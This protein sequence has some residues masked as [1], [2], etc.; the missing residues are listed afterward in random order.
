MLQFLH[1]GFSRQ[2]ASYYVR[3]KQFIPIARGIYW[4]HEHPQDPDPRVTPRILDP[5]ALAILAYRY[6]EMQLLG[7]SAYRVH[8]G[9]SPVNEKGEIFVVTSRVHHRRERELAT[10]ITLVLMPASP[11][12]EP[13]Q[14][15]V[16]EL[17]PA[18]TS[19]V[20][21]PGMAQII[22]DAISY[23]DAAP[24]S[25]NLI[26]IID[27]LTPAQ[28]NALA[29]REPL[30]AS[31]LAGWK[32]QSTAASQPARIAAFVTFP[33]TLQDQ[34][35]GAVT[36]DGMTWRFQEQNSLLPKGLIPA[37][38]VRA[39]LESLLPE[40]TYLPDED[41]EAARAFYSEPR[42]VMSF[43]T[44]EVTPIFHT[45]PRGADLALHQKGGIF[46]GRYDSSSPSKGAQSANEDYPDS[47]TPRISGAQIKRPGYIDAE[48]CLRLSHGNSPFTVIIKPDPQARNLGL[49]GLPFLEWAGQKAC[50]AAGITTPNFALITSQD[51]FSAAFLSERFDIPRDGRTDSYA[52]GVDGLAALGQSPRRKYEVQ[53]A[54]IWRA[55]LGLGVDPKQ[56]GLRLFDRTVASWAIG[57]TDFHGKNISVLRTY[58]PNNDPH[59]PARWETHLAPAYD[60]VA[61]EGFPNLRHNH[62]ALAVSKKKTGIGFREWREWGAFLHI[63]SKN[64]IDEHVE[65]IVVRASASL[66]QSAHKGVPGLS[67]GYAVRA[68]EV[69]ERAAEASQ[70]KLALL[71]LGLGSDELGSDEESA[72]TPGR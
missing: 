54:E 62:Q 22:R 48:G 58:T 9:L 8:Q 40:V 59:Q 6:P 63:G 24:D 38:G 72:V 47:L 2:Q 60:T 53:F 61:V 68:Q 52:Y 66:Q 43:T 36:Y 25:A 21:V 69:L 20:R 31:S 67:G 35:L 33:L 29:E 26:Q 51:G 27:D 55:F 30:L 70:K 15:R 65:H 17:M 5:Y 34:T 14:S 71:G 41:P 57:D 19:T 39:F 50:R 13:A 64:V 16:V 37:R 3:K 32:T 56:D 10:G 46:V 1:T 45:I 49:Q 44:G 23:P 28:R 42:R 11:D 18:V 7:E 4:I 12:Y